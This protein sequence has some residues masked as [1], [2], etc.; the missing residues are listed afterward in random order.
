MTKMLPLELKAM[1]EVPPKLA[2][3]G[4]LKDSGTGT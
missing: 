2:W 1:P 3:A 4:S